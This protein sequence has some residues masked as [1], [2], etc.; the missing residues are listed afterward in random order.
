MGSHAKLNGPSNDSLIA[1]LQSLTCQP[2]VR[3]QLRMGLSEEAGG[4]MRVGFGVL[5]TNA[6]QFGPSIL[7]RNDVGVRDM[8]LG[9][10]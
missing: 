9:H 8:I 1:L 5:A 2:T 10:G 7:A 6:A 4:L 3:K